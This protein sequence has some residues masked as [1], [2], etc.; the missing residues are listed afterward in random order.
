VNLSFCILTQRFQSASPDFV[1]FIDTDIGCRRP[2]HRDTRYW[3]R[4]WTRYRVCSVRYRWHDGRISGC[5]RYRYQY[6][7]QCDTI[8]GLIRHVPMISGYTKTPISWHMILYRVNIWPNIGENADIGV[9][10]NPDAH[11]STP[12]A[13]PASRGPGPGRTGPGGG[14]SG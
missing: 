14:G 8:S 2:R 6:R 1:S 11:F 9:V 12:T 7:C 5:N 4:Y 13:A 10:K 3:S